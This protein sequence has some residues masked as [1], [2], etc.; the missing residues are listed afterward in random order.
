MNVLIL[1]TETTGLDPKTARVIEVGTVVYSVEH[2]A[3]VSTTSRLVYSEE[4]NPM[5]A[6]NRIP[7]ELLKLGIPEDKVWAAVANQAKTCDCVLAHNSDFD[8]QWVP[9]ALD[10][11]GTP[12]GDTCYLVTWPKQTRPSSSLTQ[13]AIDHG[14]AIVDAHRAL[15]D[16]L[17]LSRILTRCAEMGH[18]IRALIAQ[19]TR[20]AAVLRALVS[21]DDRELAKMH[22]FY[23]D[24][25]QKVWTRKMA[26]E[27]AAKL[28][29]RTE[30]V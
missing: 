28:P 24:A 14:V 27:D 12:W 25:V 29:F 15:S 9:S 2:A 5:E 1:D 20:P 21:Y 26:I 3:V 8:K 17:L 22:G 13:L 30:Q 7:G 16:C 10:G 4:G 18:D 6:V 23:W 11:F 19:A